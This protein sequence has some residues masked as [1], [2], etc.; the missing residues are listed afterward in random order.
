MDDLRAGRRF[1]SSQGGRELGRRFFETLAAVI[2]G[3]SCQGGLHA[4]KFGFHRALAPKFPYSVYY[5]V[6]GDVVRVY[7]VVDNRRNPAWAES[8][9]VGAKTRAETQRDG[10]E[11]EGGA[12]FVREGAA[13]EYGE[14]KPVVYLETSFV[15]YLMARDAKDPKNIARQEATRRW[16]KEEGPKWHPVVSE[17]VK[18]ESE[19][20]DPEAVER[21]LAFMEDFE[22]MDVSAEAEALATRLMDAIRLKE[23]YRTDAVHM[24]LA[25]IRGAD[26]LLSWNCK[27]IANSVTIPKVVATLALAG[28][29]CP[30]IATPRQRLEERD[31]D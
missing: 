8:R 1:Y 6:E 4:R 29:A 12:W 23:K 24:A 31:N 30:A 11:E 10:G 25:A 28:Y 22:S 20:G 3:L 26:L 18:T 16:W 21:R 9:V 19:D 13:P 7:A 2:G 14:G 27:H 5:D 15:S 17:A